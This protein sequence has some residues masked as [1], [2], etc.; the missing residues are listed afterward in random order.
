MFHDA[1]A[2]P[3]SQ[4]GAAERACRA[5]RSGRGGRHFFGGFRGA[6]GF[7]P[8]ICRVF[9]TAG[10]DAGERRSLFFLILNILKLMK[11]FYLF[12]VLALLGWWWG[13][14]AY[15]DDVPFRQQRREIFRV[16]PTNEESIVFLG[17]SITNFG[18]WPEAFASDPRVVNRG[19][20]GNLSGEVL[21][22]LDLILAGH[23]RKV[24]LMI[25]INDFASPEVVVP[26]TRRIIEVVRRESP[27]T[28]LY[29]QSLLPCNRDDRHGMVEPINRDL[30]ALCEAEGVTYID[31]YSKLVD[32]NAARPGIAAA[33]TN[34]NLHV[35]A[36]GY[37]AW[38]SEYEQY[39]GIAPVWPQGTGQTLSGVTPFENI[40]L[41]QYSLL[42]VNDGDFLML[43]DYN[44]QAGEWAELMRTP[45]AKN[46]GIGIGW[47]YTMTL[48]TLKRVVP[49]V[50][51]GAPA[52]IFLQCGAKDLAGNASVETVYAQYVEAVEAVRAKAPD[53][54]ICLQSVIPFTDASL[55]S[56]KVVP[57]NAKL[58]AY[59]EGDATGKLHFADVYGALAEGGVLATK[60]RGANTA[61]SRGINGRGYLRWAATLAP[62][63]GGDVSPVPELGDEAF[64][65]NEALSAARRTLFN[66]VVG[67]APG[68]YAE[69]GLAPLRTAIAEAA[70]VLADPAST[71][72]QLTEQVTRLETA[73]GKMG[74]GLVYPRLSVGEEEHWYKLSTPLRNN[75][76]AENQGAGSGLFGKSETNAKNQQW[77][78]TERADGAWNI[79]SRADGSFLSPEAAADEQL[80]TTVAEPAKGWT[81]A[82]A[83]TAGRFIAHC[84]AAQLHQ[85]NSSLG[86][87]M[88]NWGG[89]S[90]V[91]DDGCQFQITPVTVEPDPDPEP[92]EVPAAWLTLVDLALDGSG[93]YRV[94]DEMARPVLEG[95]S[96]TVAIDFTLADNRS[97]MALVGSSC[98]AAADKFVCVAVAAANNFGVRFGNGGEKYTTTA[99]IGTARHQIVVTMQ[100]TN[101]SLVYYLD[102]SKARDVAA[103]VPTFGNV[104]GVNGLYLG[105]LVCSD[106]R[107][108]Y[109]MRG[110][111]HSAQFFPGVLTAEQVA[112]IDYENLAQTQTGIQ[113]LDEITP[114]FRIE[115]GRVV[116]ANAASASLYDLSGRLQPGLRIT[117]PGLYV[118]VIA[119]RSYKIVAR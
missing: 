88:I 77:K 36:A 46:R 80:R 45:K 18:V 50:V 94:P 27:Q 51:K 69:E 53:A 23:P 92:V 73:A 109:P 91:E 37:R 41:S 70:A 43:G 68:N 95:E 47:G 87:K 20:S 40:M 107:N 58:R 30:K 115:N 26:N 31:V 1:P 16:L 60:F 112:A 29:V 22:H 113:N 97:E 54:D 78:F 84:G 75:M 66:A 3:L 12:C 59:V 25:G 102:G 98:D 85:T 15:A 108:K 86:F 65:L 83:S 33:Y 62:F 55:N 96:V 119:G 72:T 57:F 71:A 13:A 101:P 116:T 111:I 14:G 56:S 76:F 39:T 49:L 48:A 61:Q 93:P 42:P 99:S 110:T 67:D 2:R 21:E 4:A 100:P 74:E 32:N 117:A 104:E 106:N 114:A 17:N 6:G 103:V 8:Y 105:G 10:T 89:G 19:I 90:N 79:V 82:P 63:M 118:L 34:D 35:T 24:F 9:R 28:T 38:T 44:V 81:L 64:A 7:S 5:G 52:G 11:R